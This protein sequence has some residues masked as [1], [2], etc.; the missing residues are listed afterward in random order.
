MLT[1][2][3]F[4]P[5]HHVLQRPW[6]K[7]AHHATQSRDV[8]Q[9]V[10]NMSASSASDTRP[11]QKEKMRCRRTTDSAAVFTAQQLDDLLESKVQMLPTFV[12]TT[13]KQFGLRNFMNR[14][15]GTCHT[16]TIVRIR[17]REYIRRRSRTSISKNT[18]ARTRQT[19][20]T[21]LAERW[22]DDPMLSWCPS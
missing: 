11:S 14:S 5:L 21:V 3:F 22:E 1:F 8:N 13:V 12:V 10:S 19:V 6:A 9:K 7:F 15:S 20:V 2:T 16:V 18:L 17:W 4:S